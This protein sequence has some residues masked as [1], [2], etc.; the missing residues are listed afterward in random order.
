MTGR[1]DGAALADAPAAPDRVDGARPA[2]PLP[3]AEVLSRLGHELRSPLNGIIGLSRIMQMKLARSQPDV[4]ELLRQLEMVT[5]SAQ[6]AL[7]TIDRVAQVARVDA[8]PP[9]HGEAYD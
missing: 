1:L 2:A 6:Q 3:G 8:A 7:V 9:P 4:E 5:A